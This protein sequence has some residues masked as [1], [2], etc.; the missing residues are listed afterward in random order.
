MF[1]I[2]D[3]AGETVG[4]PKTIADRACDQCKSRKVRCDMT[5][6]CATCTKQG[7][8]CTY[9]KARKKRGPTGKHIE[10]I[11]RQQ[12]KPSDDQ[13]GSQ[14]SSDL[15]SSTCY[16]AQ[17]I[18]SP[19]ADQDSNVLSTTYDHSVSDEQNSYCATLFEESIGEATLAVI[20]SRMPSE[21]LFPSLPIDSPS[22]DLDSF[23]LIPRQELPPLTNT[24]DVWPQTINEEALLPWIDVYFKRLN[25][26]G[27]I[28]NRTT[29][30]HEMIM[31]KH[32]TDSQYGAMIFGLCAF[33]MYQPIQIHEHASTPSR[34][35]QAGMLME[36]CVKMRLT[37]EFGEHPSIEMVLT[38]LFLFSCLFN[39]NK[40]RA[41]ALRLREAV[42]LAQNLGLHLPESYPELDAET[43][44]QWLRT[45]LSL[46]VTERAY[47]LQ[48]RHYISFRGRPGITARFMQ[49]F[50][51]EYISHFTSSDHSDSVAMTGLLYLMETFDNIDETVIECWNGNC[52]VSDGICESFD[53]RRALQAF[54]AQYRAHEA[55][56]TGNIS[57]APS[58]TPVPLDE[59]TES[60]QADILITQ[61][62]LLNRLWSLCLSHSLLRESSDHAELCYMFACHIALSLNEQCKR[63]PLSALEIHGIGLVEKIFDVAMGVITAMGVSSCITLDMPLPKPEPDKVFINGEVSSNLALKDILQNFNRTI[64]DFRGGGHQ[65]SDRFEDILTKLPGYYL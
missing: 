25:P 39:S 49:A 50:D 51:R 19:P 60:Q 15:N 41:A 56:L 33:A 47:A 40:Q 61:L 14:N 35:V 5:K 20:P 22:H 30:Y 18:A 12:E 10:E 8:D 26:I 52:K 64:Q 65:Y 4:R 21:V 42:D 1:S 2:L 46:S 28:L 9:A 45:Y 13:D 48:R 16:S 38:S 17:L 43:R 58:A 36:E 37:A 55:C 57:F 31:R 27:P 7:F 59:L 32:R 11:R 29:I 63:F 54:R 34:W 6:P 62:W 3:C 44:E 53:R 24:A 23:G